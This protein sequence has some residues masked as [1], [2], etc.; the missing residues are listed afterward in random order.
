MILPDLLIVDDEALVLFDMVMTAEELGYTVSG[1]CTSVPQALRFLDKQTPDAA[2]LDIDVGGTM[3]W[4]VAR[5]L[6]ERGSAIVFVSANRAHREL[7]GEFAQCHFIDK[8][9]CATQIA[10]RLGDALAARKDNPDCQRR[11]AAMPG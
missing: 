5:K 8:P 1:D 4:P 10:G 3:V 6:A 11:V 9:A 2:L 7:S